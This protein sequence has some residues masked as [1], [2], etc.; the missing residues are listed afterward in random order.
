MEIKTE[1]HASTNGAEVEK[2]KQTASIVGAASENE[3]TPTVIAAAKADAVKGDSAGQPVETA[4]T[5]VRQ[6]ASLAHQ[7]EQRHKHDSAEVPNGAIKPTNAPET[8]SSDDP[9]IADRK[10]ALGPLSN[11][12]NFYKARG[13]ASYRDGDFA[14]A[15]VNFN[16]A[17]RLH[18][19]D[20]Q[21]YNI[22]GNAW[23]EMGFFER[24][25]ADYDEAIRIDPNSPAVF[26]DRAI[27]WQRKG[28]LDKALIDLDRAIRFSFSDVNMYCDRGLVWYEK[29]RHDRAVADFNQ[30]MK[31]DP[32]FATACIKRGLIV[33]RNSEFKLALATVNQAIRVD[34]S[35]FDALRRTNSLP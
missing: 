19:D 3:N 13:I 35:I 22:R 7:G 31:L 33:H 1:A 16:A 8:N 9:D 27:L 4:G 14:Q 30:A 26:H 21:A 12:G 11:N 2:D 5:S 28:E 25:L 18:P 15:I 23:D 24:A 10:L 32:N 6:P 17:I 34:P 20:A 29:G